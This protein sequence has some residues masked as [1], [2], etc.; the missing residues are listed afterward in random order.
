MK[1]VK[2]VKK[3]T[4]GKQKAYNKGNRKS[5]AVVQGAKKKVRIVGD[6]DSFIPTTEP[7]K[8]AKQTKPLNK[9]KNISKETER[10][11]LMPPYTSRRG[12]IK[13]AKQRKSM[14]KHPLVRN[15]GESSAEG[16][17]LAGRG[18]GIPVK[19]RGK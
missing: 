2:A 9:N 8:G 7:I 5:I 1:A 15:A 13:F 17:Y 10:Y 19:K 11:S 3:I 12:A 6:N 4:T 14:D 18:K 16:K